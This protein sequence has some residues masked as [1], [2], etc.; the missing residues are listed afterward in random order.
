[1]G[2]PTSVTGVAP[3]WDAIPSRATSAD[4]GP[5]TVE[6]L[7]QLENYGNIPVFLH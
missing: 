1:M 4:D 7:I 5:V 2:H 6:R 3:H